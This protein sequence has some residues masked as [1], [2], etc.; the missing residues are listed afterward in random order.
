MQ[1]IAKEYKVEW[2]STDIGL[3]VPTT[4]TD[5]E[6][7]GLTQNRCRRSACAMSKIYHQKLRNALLLL[8]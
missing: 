3:G 5:E 8:C 6:G 1:E 2:T 4:V 7:T